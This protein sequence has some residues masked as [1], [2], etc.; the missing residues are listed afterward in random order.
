MCHNYSS[1]AGP[2]V[3]TRWGQ[4]GIA[5][6]L[7]GSS[8]RCNEC[9]KYN[10]GCEPVAIAQIMRLNQKPNWFTYDGMPDNYSKFVCTTSNAQENELA[11]L[12]TYSGSASGLN[13]SYG[14]WGTCSTFSY[15]WNIPS[16]FSNFGYSSCG[17]STDIDYQVV[18]NEL[19]GGHP[20]ILWGT[21]DWVGNFTDYHIWICDGI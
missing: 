11:R 15:P 1:S 4:S 17:S 10:A 21:T 18:K 14:Y 7:L 13:S 19:F 8:S 16:A 12:M 9:D 6:F 20:V 3:N 2:F 5:T